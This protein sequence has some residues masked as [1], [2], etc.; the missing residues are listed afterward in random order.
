MRSVAVR[1]QCNRRRLGQPLSDWIALHRLA[2][3][4]TNHLWW[5][6]T[7]GAA[8]GTFAMRAPGDAGSYEFAIFRT[9][10]M[11]IRPRAIASP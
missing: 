5:A 1:A 6:Y 2:D 11:M 3:S 7:N 10:A 8:R 4:N 9:M